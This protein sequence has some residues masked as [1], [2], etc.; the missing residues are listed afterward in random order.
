MKD[1]PPE[2]D[3]IKRL[4]EALLRLQEENAKWREKSEEA[5]VIIRQRAPNADGLSLKGALTIILNDRDESL[6]RIQFFRDELSRV[7]SLLLDD[8]EE[9]AKNE[10]NQFLYKN[11]R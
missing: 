1:F 8:K 7:L 9:E 4:Q 10:L 6:D 11:R 5:Q 2:S 3:N